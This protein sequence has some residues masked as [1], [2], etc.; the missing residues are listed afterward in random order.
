M[1][2]GIIIAIALA[3]GF[4]VFL[5]KKIKEDK[6]KKVDVNIETKFRQEVVAPTSPDFTRDVGEEKETWKERREENR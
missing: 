2:L 1:E 5:Y 4:G 3:L 6:K